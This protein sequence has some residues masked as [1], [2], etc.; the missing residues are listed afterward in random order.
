VLLAIVTQEIPDTPPPAPVPRAA[1][2]V[3]RFLF[4]LVRAYNLDSNHR[5]LIVAAFALAVKIVLWRRRAQLMGLGAE[6]NGCSAAP[7]CA[8]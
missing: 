3:A 7:R 1:A 8:R 6:S 4:E 2:S 5:L